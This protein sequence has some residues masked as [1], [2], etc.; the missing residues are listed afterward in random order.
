MEV[1]RIHHHRNHL[2]EDG[3]DLA[4]KS[5]VVVTRACVMELQ[6][7]CLAVIVLMKKEYL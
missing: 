1:L 5:A 6:V 4:Q 7:T 2:H 3:E